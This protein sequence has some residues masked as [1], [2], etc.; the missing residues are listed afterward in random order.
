MSANN[1]MNTGYSKTDLANTLVPTIA[2]LS[3]GMAA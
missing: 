1:P 3:R 2:Q